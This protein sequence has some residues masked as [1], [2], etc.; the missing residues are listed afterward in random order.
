M[1][2]QGLVGDLV[3]TNAKEMDVHDPFRCNSE[4]AIDDH[5]RA[6]SSSSSASAVALFTLGWRL[7]MPVRCIVTHGERSMTDCLAD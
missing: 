6:A 5:V 2:G 7:T 4:C 3:E 1:P